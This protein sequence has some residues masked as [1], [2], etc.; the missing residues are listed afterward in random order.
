MAEKLEPVRKLKKPDG[1]IVYFLNGKLHNWDE[2]AVI[3]PSGK[4]EYWLF[5]FQ[6]SKDDFMDRKREQHGIPPAKN[7]K[8]DS[9]F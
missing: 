1:T 7:P 4:K 2:P 3:H 9:S 5:G 8:Y 6:Y